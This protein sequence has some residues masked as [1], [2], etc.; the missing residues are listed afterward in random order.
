[1]TDAHRKRPDTALLKQAEQHTETVLPGYTHM[2]RGQP[3][4]FGHHLLAY[5]EMFDRDAGRFLAANFLNQENVRWTSGCQ[6]DGPSQGTAHSS[7][8]PR[9]LEECY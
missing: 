8:W 9:F 5:F 4:V 7:G 6:T 3:I 1:M 2:Q